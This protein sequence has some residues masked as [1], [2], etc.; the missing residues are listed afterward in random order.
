MRYAMF[1]KEETTRLLDIANIGTH[2]GMTAQARAIYNAVLQFNNT[3][4]GALLGLAF[5]HITVSQYDEAEKILNAVIAKNSDDME[6]KCL[7][8]LNYFLADKKELAK[9]LLAEAANTESESKA[10]AQDLLAEMQHGLSW[11]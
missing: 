6:A 9:P 1:S 8:G 2:K 3:H 10:L 4:T 11:N 5:N 7:L